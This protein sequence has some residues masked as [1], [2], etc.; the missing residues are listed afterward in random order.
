MS[1]LSQNPDARGVVNI[2]SG[3]ATELS[4]LVEILIDVSGKKVAIETISSRTRPEELG[5]VVGSTALLAKL[6]AAPPQIDYADVVGRV[7]KAAEALFSGV[8]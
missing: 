4:K 7:W 5:V 3:R 8:S 6:G 1:K 2:C